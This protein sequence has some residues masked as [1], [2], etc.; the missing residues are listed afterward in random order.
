MIFNDIANEDT[1]NLSSKN[2]I[3][4]FR[5][6]ALGLYAK[7]YLSNSSIKDENLNPP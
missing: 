7:T 2:C 1:S 3:F 6:V 4:K 5:C